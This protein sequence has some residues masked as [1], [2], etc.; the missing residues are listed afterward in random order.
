[1][2]VLEGVCALNW[3]LALEG[4]LTFAGVF[5]AKG[6]LAENKEV[7]RRGEN[8]NPRTPITLWVAYR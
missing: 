7:T 3:V 8:Q 1:M 2:L 6:V 4:V 5:T